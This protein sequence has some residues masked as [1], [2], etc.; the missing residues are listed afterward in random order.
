MLTAS[1]RSSPLPSP[2]DP[3]FDDADDFD[4]YWLRPKT[5]QPGRP[6]AVARSSSVTG[7]YSV[8]SIGRGFDWDPS[9]HQQQQGRGEGKIAP[10][11]FG[12]LTKPEITKSPVAATASTSTSTLTTSTP[13]LTLPNS[14]N[15]TT[16]TSALTSPPTTTMTQ[17][18]DSLDTV[19]DGSSMENGPE[20][21]TQE[22]DPLLRRLH[23]A[24]G[25]E[26]H[27]TPPTPPPSSSF[28]RPTLSTSLSSPS[29]SLAI[30][31]STTS[32]G[33]QSYRPVFNDSP[34]SSRPHSPLLSSSKSLSSSPTSRFYHPH[35]FL[36]GSNNAP[37]ASAGQS[38]HGGRTPT[39]AR[40]SRRNSQQRVSLIAGRVSI[41][42]ASPPRDDDY[43]LPF[44]VGDPA[45]VNGNGSR[46]GD[47]IEVEGRGGVFEVGGAAVN[48]GFGPSWHLQRTGSTSSFLS[49]ARTTAPPTRAGSP[50]SSRSS[51]SRSHSSRSRSQS[52]VIARRQGGMGRMGRTIS[53]F[54]IDADLGRGAYGL[55]K[56]GREIGTDGS[57]GPPTVLKYIIKQR[58]LA[59]CWKRH[60]EHG[61]I[62][63]EI[64]VMAGVSGTS[65][66]LPERR[67]WDPRR[68]GGDVQAE[69][70]VVGEGGEVGK[71]K[72]EGE[73][74]WEEGMTVH[75]HP[76]ICPLL[77]FFEDDHYYYLMLPSVAPTGV[78]VGEGLPPPPT[79]L[80]DLVEAYP[81]GLPAR[82]VR[83][84]LGQIA[85][86]V[87]F[88]HERGIVHRDLK[89][90]N[91]VLGPDGR[92]ILIDFG[93]SGI[94][95]KTGWDTFS[96]TLDYAGPEILRGERYHGKEQ[97]VWA[98]GVVAYVLLVGECPFQ[99]A[100]E[101]QEGLGSPF[102]PAVMGLEER[103][104][105]ERADEGL[106]KDGGGRLGDAARL[107]RECLRVEVKER[108]SMERVMRSRFL[109]GDGGW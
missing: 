14:D 67:G 73:D 10:K 109:W 82:D 102:S 71:G 75:G 49:R 92:C 64:Y 11:R 53:D 80:F 13:T 15:T 40:Q 57:L 37:F 65:Y 99:N 51:H 48:E 5:Q 16:Y 27:V 76:N 93:S 21:P 66:V 46:S 42:P 50:D 95:K 3:V 90:E 81:K 100:A 25:N 101:A 98:F 38:Q 70:A 28:D 17:N 87:A 104:G 89:D 43:P 69:G 72:G 1:T 2:F 35:P 33:R 84:Y 23:S 108:P 52:P 107:V 6:Q 24:F 63:I 29:L 62:P 77:D 26:A 103:C 78:R 59:D 45:A 30:P 4:D 7:G 47:G 32:L 39:S 55:V 8:T 31:T 68:P 74:W 34:L 85:D 105:E 60:P 79:D 106:E 19:M 86:A 18:E 61:T 54:V 41:A 9:Q 20:K 58:I 83:T 44:G 91:V 22:N 88:L 96:G 94:V 36:P 12:G 56:R 97:D